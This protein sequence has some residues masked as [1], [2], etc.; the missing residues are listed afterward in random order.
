[1]AALEVLTD[2]GVHALNTAA[3]SGPRLVVECA[4]VGDKQVLGSTESAEVYAKLTASDIPSGSSEAT[5]PCVAMLPS[6]VVFGDD[7]EEGA[8]ASQLEPRNAIDIEFS[9]LPSDLKEFDAIAVL[10]RL[11]YGY[12]EYL[13]GQYTE[14]QIVWYRE[15][16]GETKYYRCTAYVEVESV[17]RSPASD[18]E[19]WEEVVMT[20]RVIGSDP[21]LRA[22]DEASSL[23]L[24]H[25][26]T[27]EQKIVVGQGLEFNYKLR[28]FLNSVSFDMGDKEHCPVYLESLV[29]AGDAALQLGF[30][31]EMS[32]SMATMRE[33]IANAYGK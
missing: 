15:S 23:I 25:V 10:A 3:V 9:W 20:D 11:Y 19:H 28:I 26:S 30:L 16:S 8:E 21:P 33:I 27:T 5:M 31:K 13:P 24:L 1:M 7:T 22:P 4:W 29:P 18:T 14:G 32:Q 17:T 6:T 2:E 12:A